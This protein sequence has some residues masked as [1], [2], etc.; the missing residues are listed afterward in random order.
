MGAA[1]PSLVLEM[2]RGA[3]TAFGLAWNEHPVLQG[4]VLT[5]SEPFRSLWGEQLAARPLPAGD[6]K[7]CGSLGGRP[8]WIQG[9]KPQ[10]IAILSRFSVSCSA[11]TF[12]SFP[13]SL[14]N[15]NFPLQT[16]CY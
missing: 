12:P 13:T 16:T 14:V 11:P 9:E 8:G 15:E 1:E 4:V 10:P 6:P 5:L 7:A 2:G 3:C